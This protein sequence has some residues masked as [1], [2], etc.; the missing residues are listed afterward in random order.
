MPTSQTR[1]TR[2]AVPVLALAAWTIALPVMGCYRYVPVADNTA[3]KPGDVTLQLTSEGTKAVQ[4]TLGQNVRAIDGAL[5]RA[6]A[7]SLELLVTDV[8]TVTRERFPQNN[9][10]TTIARAHV[11]QS[12]QKVFSRKRT[13]ALV[14]GAVAVVATALGATTAASASSSGQGGNGG[15]QP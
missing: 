3:P 14:L 13:W 2:A 1:T 6:T 5:V 9:V 8:Y 15:I 4:Q 11:E 12:A 10:S 7:D